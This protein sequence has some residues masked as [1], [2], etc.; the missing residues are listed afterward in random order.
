MLS[1]STLHNS[2][3]KAPTAM[4]TVRPTTKAPNAISPIRPTTKQPYTMTTATVQ[5][6]TPT[7][8]SD[9]GIST[10]GAVVIF[11]YIVCMLLLILVALEAKKK[12]AKKLAEEMR[13]AEERRR[14]E[15][16]RQEAERKEQE[17]QKSEED[18]LYALFNDLSVVSRFRC[19]P[20]IGVGPY[21]YEKIIANFLRLGGY[22]DARA[23][24]KSGDYGADV[25]GTG[26]NG[27][28]MCAQ[29]KMFNRPVGLK[30]I[31]EVVAA[32]AVYG[33]THAMVVSTSDFTEHAVQL[34]RA[35]GVKLVVYSD[36]IR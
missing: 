1:D 5:V 27:E 6:T 23:T 13:I 17:K 30:P 24:S 15:L 16:Q 4:P 34:A 9:E 8:K 31:Q 29:C 11:L 36:R 21:E 32:K 33:C 3:T 19:D 28:K 20:L 14:I 7:T 35:N 25:I 26:L 2:R 10:G 22:H 18:R 12:K